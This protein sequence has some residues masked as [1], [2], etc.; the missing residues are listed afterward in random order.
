MNI[1]NLAQNIN[2]IVG[3]NELRLPLYYLQTAILPGV[4]F[5][6][7]EAGTR[8]GSKLHFHADS[9]TF[10]QLNLGFLLAEDF[11]NYNEFI[12]RIY[13]EYNPKNGTFKTNDFNLFLIPCNLKGSSLYSVVFHNCK[14]ESIDDIDLSTN[15]DSDFKTFNVNIV[16]DYYLIDSDRQ[17]YISFIKQF[18]ND[19]IIKKMIEKL[20][21]K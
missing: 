4:S 14:L 15:D 5:S 13:S 16:Y 11:S 18:P 8:Y 20:N 2:F 6:H 3:S 10:N 7:P 12:N 1:N 9:L 19:P 17:K 21:L